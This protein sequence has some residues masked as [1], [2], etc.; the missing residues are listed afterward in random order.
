MIVSEKTLKWALNFYPP[1]L[2]QRIWIKKFHKDFKGVEVKINNSLFNKNYNASIFGGTIFSATDPFYAILFDQIMQRKGYKCRVWLKSASIQYLKPG[3]T[4]LF[5]TINISDEMIKEAEQSLQNN[6][7]FVKA[8]LIELFDKNG[9]KCAVV[10]NE[11]Y[12]RNKFPN[13]NQKVA[14]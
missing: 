4:D 14:I 12:L 2:F 6:G 7:K 8:Y 9:V 5:F 11:V 13:E 10:S 1:L 3:R